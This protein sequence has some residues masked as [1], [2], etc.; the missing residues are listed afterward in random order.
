MSIIYLKYVRVTYRLK[1]KA[2]WSF[3]TLHKYFT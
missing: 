3:V 1:V 2:L